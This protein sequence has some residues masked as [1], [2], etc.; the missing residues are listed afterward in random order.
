MIFAGVTL[1]K[2]TPG[3][4]DPLHFR[5]KM[6][7]KQDKRSVD[8]YITDSAIQEAKNHCSSHILFEEQIIKSLDG[9]YK[10]LNKWQISKEDK[11]GMDKGIG[12]RVENI[13]IRFG[14]TKQ[15]LAEVIQAI[16]KVRRQGVEESITNT[17]RNI[18]SAPLNNLKEEIADA[19]IMLNQL[20]LIFHFSRNKQYCEL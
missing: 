13:R 17:E 20:M 7:S 16:S 8:L 2:I 11:F 9:L 15:E 1:K 6:K 10:R 19:L 4:E 18:D 12:A 3:Q 14:E 5:I